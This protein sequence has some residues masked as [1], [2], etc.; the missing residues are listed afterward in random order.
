M[1]MNIS[2]GF[3]FSDVLLPDVTIFKNFWVREICFHFQN[4]HNTIHNKH[5]FIFCK[6]NWPCWSAIISLDYNSIN[7]IVYW[8]RGVSCLARYKHIK[9]IY[10]CK[11]EAPIFTYVIVI[12]PEDGQCKWPKHVAE[13][14][15]MHTLKVLCSVG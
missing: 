10:I 14:K 5:S 11:R 12:L 3:V 7:A 13:D 15:W 4:E 2:R 1:F 9:N 8:C 6:I